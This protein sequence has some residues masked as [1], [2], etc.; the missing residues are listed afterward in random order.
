M[1]NVNSAFSN[2]YLF[3]TKKVKLFFTGFFSSARNLSKNPDTTALFSTRTKKQWKKVVLFLSDVKF[4][5]LNDLHP[6]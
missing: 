6:R 5:F 2:N 4:V 1:S 3:D